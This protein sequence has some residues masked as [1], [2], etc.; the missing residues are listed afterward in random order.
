M[1]F[2]RLTETNI[3]KGFISFVNRMQIYF[4]YFINPIFYIKKS[5]NLDRLT[6]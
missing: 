2:I 1:I 3:Q 6:Y 4:L 5:D